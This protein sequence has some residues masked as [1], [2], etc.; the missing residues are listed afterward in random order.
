[1]PGDEIGKIM[2]LLDFFN[3][4]E[5]PQNAPTPSLTEVFRKAMD[6]LSLELRVGMPAK[7]IKYDHEKQLVDVQPDFKR[8]YKDGKVQDPPVIYSVPVAFF[9][10]GSAFISVPLEK[11]HQ[12]W[13]MFSDRSLEKWLS[14]GEQGDPEDT[15]AHHI[16]DAVA[17]P[18]VYSFATP[19]AINN[20]K[21]IIIKNDDGDGNILEIRVKKNG[22]VQVLNKQEELIKVLSD[23][24]QTI[25]NAVVYTSTGPQKLKHKDFSKNHKRLNTFLEK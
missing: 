7:V 9:R 6:S 1:M 5:Q 14:S 13:L 20:P 21:D 22:H 3:E 24:V 10:A 16:S 17:F 12:V 15:R 25:R 11:G 18:G 19:A 8:K 4:K 23:L 2:G